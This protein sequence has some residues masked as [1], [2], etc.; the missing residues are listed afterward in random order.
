MKINGL[1]ILLCIFATLNSYSQTI[2]YHSV[3]DDWDP[4]SLGN[5][6]AIIDFRGSGPIAKVI[7]EWRLNMDSMDK[8]R[9]IIQDAKTGRLIRHQLTGLIGNESAEIY[10][11]PVSGA[12][13]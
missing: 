6:R 11:E 12:G 9:I 8:K 13:L 4:D 7:L 1:P 3:H 5:H 2:P 10:F